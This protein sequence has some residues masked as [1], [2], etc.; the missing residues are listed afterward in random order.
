MVN[1]Q[2]GIRL[3][4]KLKI[5]GADFAWDG[6]KNSTVAKVNKVT[7]RTQGTDEL[8]EGASADGVLKGN[9]GGWWMDSVR[10]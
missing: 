10:Q 6:D 4:C 1:E 3:A 5:V 7:G 9:S 8:D 2:R